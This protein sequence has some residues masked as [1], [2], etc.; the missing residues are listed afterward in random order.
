MKTLILLLFSLVSFAGFAQNGFPTTIT[1]PR[2]TVS[3]AF[4]IDEIVE[5]E[6]QQLS[7]TFGVSARPASTSSALSMGTMPNYNPRM[8]IAMYRKTYV[9]WQ[10]SWPVQLNMGNSD[11]FAVNYST[12]STAAKRTGQV[13]YRRNVN[14]PLESISLSGHRVGD[15]INAVGL[16][17]LTLMTN[18]L[19]PQAN[20]K[21]LWL[22]DS[23]T[24][25][26]LNGDMKQEE[27]MQWGVQAWINNQAKSTSGNVYRSVIVARG[28]MKS[29]D[30][31]NALENRL[32][33]VENPTFVVSLFGLNDQGQGVPVNTYE[34]NTRR[35]LAILRRIYPDAIIVK[36]TDTPVAN[37]TKNT[38]VDAYRNKLVE[39][40]T[41]LNDPKIKVIDLRKAFDRTLGLSVWAA[42]DSNGGAVNVV[43]DGVHPGTA[44]SHQG[45]IN[46][47]TTG[48]NFDGTTTTGLQQLGITF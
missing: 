20:R 33:R 44:L 16:T 5:T 13:E 40:V 26:T 12:I 7:W 2:L 45:L 19:N 4:N 17:E 37:T 11:W 23:R 42:S 28:G 25:G 48:T 29:G 6:G 27:I 15:S 22:G 47:I 18:D 35:E 43:T 21:I 46:V 30:I 1:N 31:V 10:S 36:L 41:G 32:I 34:A 38:A 3:G 8:F 9:E 14:Y 24:V 39:V